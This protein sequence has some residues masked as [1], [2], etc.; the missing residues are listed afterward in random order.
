MKQHDLLPLKILKG[1][2]VV[3][4]LFLAVFV[5]SFMGS[6]FGGDDDRDNP[7]AYGYDSLEAAAEPVMKVKVWRVNTLE[8]NDYPEDKWYSS[9]FYDITELPLT[10]GSS[11]S[12]VVDLHNPSI[13]STRVTIQ[14]DYEGPISGTYELLYSGALV[15]MATDTYAPHLNYSNDEPVFN[16]VDST[17]SGTNSV[18]MTIEDSC[19]DLLSNELYGNMRES[20]AKRESAG[21]FKYTDYYEFQEIT[22]VYENV[23]PEID[24]L[25]RYVMTT[26]LTINAMDPI[27]QDVA[28]AT[29][30]L[31][32][33]T[34]SRWFEFSSSKELEI[35]EAAGY[36]DEFYT[37]VTVVSYEQSE[38]LALE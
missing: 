33:K 30:V 32:L 29:A 18:T 7:L 26:H 13:T 37:T 3:I 12:N 20:L 10:E 38:M 34:Y 28:V 11:L 25:K 15:Y 17:F 2:G 27:K 14:I 16:S 19:N 21:N 22:D 4:A 24:K 31:E 23:P 1:V 36:P 8:R 9:R 6:R 5:Y 35:F